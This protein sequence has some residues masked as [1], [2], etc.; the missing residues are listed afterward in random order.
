MSYDIYSTL[1]SEQRE[2][3]DLMLE[4]NYILLRCDEWA[5]EE[6]DEHSTLSTSVS[7]IQSLQPTLELFGL[8]ASSYPTGSISANRHYYEVLRNYCGNAFLSTP[9]FNFLRYGLNNLVRLRRDDSS[10]NLSYLF[11]SYYRIAETLAGR[12]SKRYRH[13][14]VSLRHSATAL[15]I[16]CEES[17]QT[18]TESLQNSLVAFMDRIKR[19]LSR[20]ED[21]EKDGYRHLTLVSAVNT[22]KATS[23]RFRTSDLTRRAKALE[24]DC[25]SE[26]LSS[27][28]IS[29]GP[30]GEYSW[31]TPSTA[32]SKMAKY[33]FYLDAFVLAQVPALLNHP[34][35]QSVVRRMLSN[36]MDSHIG[37]GVPLHRL[38]NFPTLQAALP[39]FGATAACLFLLWYC[40]DN[41]TGGSE[42]LRYC[43]S[44][45]DWLRNFCLG[46]YDQPCFYVLPHSENNTKVLL[47]PRFNYD[48]MRVEAVDQHIYDLKLAINE[49]MERKGNLN[50]LFRKI[51]APKYDHIK[52]IIEGWQIPRY[53]KN[54]KAWEFTGWSEAG[55]FIGGLGVGTLKALTS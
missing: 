9:E 44:N 8:D 26:L 20:N 41:D 50:R 46:A 29:R 55:E 22:F 7:W 54:Q 6:E 49:E 35:A 36:R 13:V 24:H 12:E 33:E 25:L 45:F 15:W 14:E 42:W 5:F 40:L 21:W 39:D 38:V 47:L 28:C 31:D 16:L 2:R 53:W 10:A 52:E 23:R 3:Y 30:D 51:S 1:S 34:K 37:Y 17:R 48:E 32:K 43:R 18:L 11:G 4:T 27:R 19:Y